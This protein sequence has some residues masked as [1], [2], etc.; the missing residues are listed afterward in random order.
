MR[1]RLRRAEPDLM[2]MRLVIRIGGLGTSIVT[3][4]TQFE[5]RGLLEMVPSLPRLE[6]RSV[7][8]GAGGAVALV[9]FLSVGLRLW[10]ADDPPATAAMKVEEPKPVAA[11]AA[12]A[13]VQARQSDGP[14]APR[15]AVAP[16]VAVQ[17]DPVQKLRSELA[18]ARADCLERLHATPAYR[19]AKSTLDHLEADVNRL[20]E[21]DPNRELAKTSVQWIEAK[22]NLKRLTD[23]ALRSD[24][25]VARIEQALRDHGIGLPVTRYRPPRRDPAESSD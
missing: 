8:T 17:V 14:P 16:P 18:A 12:P 1:R 4:V 6:L 22:S 24:T 15:A 21:H 7:L 19:N 9:L 5:P 11:V 10:G 25:E 13:G 23:T 2:M 3:R 20:R